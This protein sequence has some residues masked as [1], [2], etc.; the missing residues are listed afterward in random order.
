M[1]SQITYDKLRLIKPDF[2][3]P[4]IEQIIHLEKLRSK[5]ISGS[6][7]PKIFFQ[8]K[9]I[10]HTMESIGSARIEGNRT[11]IAAYIESKITPPENPSEDIQE[12]ANIEKALEFIET[13]IKEYPLSRVF[14]SE[15]H[16]IVV[17]GLSRE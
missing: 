13:N 14:I 5:H 11:T 16:K 1:S 2:D 17:A 4:L 10:F 7:H 6:S 3:S 12:I 9:N 8:L 15:I